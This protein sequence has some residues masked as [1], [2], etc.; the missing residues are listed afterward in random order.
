[1]FQLTQEEYKSL[2]FQ[3]GILEKGQ[4]SKY[5][6]NAFT[7]QGV[8]MLSGLL[9]SPRAV[10]VNIEIMRAFVRL[11][12]ILLSHT[13]LARKI[14]FDLKEKQARYSIKKIRGT[15]KRLF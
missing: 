10:L 13:E 5:L 8:A 15:G 1:M 7:E 12:Q 3:F 4:H 6:P 14:G 9:N 2:R 11:R